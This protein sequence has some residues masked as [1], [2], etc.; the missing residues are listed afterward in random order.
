VK[1][2]LR[3]RILPLLLVS[4]IFLPRPAPAEDGFFKPYTGFRPAEDLPEDFRARIR[5]ITFD[6]RDAFAG[7]TAHGSLDRKL[8]RIGNRLH[9]VSRESTIRRRLLFREGGL[10][11]KK[12]LTESEKALRSEEFLADAILEAKIID[13]S[14]CDIRV[15]TFDQFT[16]IP[17][18]GAMN[19]ALKAGDLFSGSWSRITGGEWLWSAGLVE[20]NLLGTGTKVGA[21][22][23]HDLERDTKEL[24]FTNNNLSPQKLQVTA[25][26]AL[27]SDGHSLILKVEKPLLSSRDRYGYSLNLASL[28]TSERLYY[29]DN[30][31]DTL[32]A[33]EAERASG[34]PHVVRLFNRVATQDINLGGTASFGEGLKFDIGPVFDYRD[35]YN[36]GGLGPAD[37]SLLKTEALPASA[38]NPETRTDAAL[39]LAMSLYRYRY[40]SARNYHNLKWNESVATGWRLTAKAALNQEWLGATYGDYKLFGEA[41]YND[42]WSDL[43][44]LNLIAT[45]QSFVDARG[46]WRDGQL[47]ASWEGQ[48]KPRPITATILSSSWSQ[49]YGAPQS[50]QL[51]LGAINGLSGYPSYYYAGQA[52]IL[53]TAE[54]RVF[55]TFELLTFVPAFSAFVSAGNTFPSYEAFDPENLHYSAGLGLRLGR[56]KSTQKIVQHWN[57]CWPV[58]DAHLRGP[59]IS[60]VAK[61]SL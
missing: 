51:L 45:W 54:Q 9:V 17:V 1:T 28:E 41:A 60:V 27:L 39:G 40:Q 52:R 30:L 6:R 16:T 47:D 56:S 19:P 22:F 58:G 59:I 33:G 13:D 61:K 11:D 49:L 21:V 57:V 43:A 20:T 15:T 48:W 14:I 25:Y 23:R 3:R 53:A 26:S 4:C 32:P 37:T 31:L 10:A 34:V 38:L 29:D 55:P 35:R 44:Y 2:S 7:S 24:T 8:F 46:R 18:A 12:L 42:A 50:R 5:S 36:V